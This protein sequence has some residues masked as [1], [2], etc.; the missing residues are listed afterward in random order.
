M[1]SEFACPHCE[2]PSVVYPDEGE[3][4]VVCAGCG[5]FLATRSQFRR[6]VEMRERY[7]EIR[8]SG[9]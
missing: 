6:L 9:C 5:A 3:D 2:S 7:S 8:T 1:G 4:R